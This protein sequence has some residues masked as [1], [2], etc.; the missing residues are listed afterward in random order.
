MGC[1]DGAV[2]IIDREQENS[3][4]ERRLLVAKKLKFLRFQKKNKVKT[5]KVASKQRKD[6]EPKCRRIPPVIQGNLLDTV[7]SK[8]KALS[9]AY[10]KITG[11]GTSQTSRIVNGFVLSDKQRRW[12]NYFCSLTYG[13]STTPFCG[14]SYIGRNIVITAAHCVDWLSS[15]ANLRVRFNKRYLTSS[16]LT[17]RVKRI[18]VHPNY[19]ENTYN[20]DIAILWLRGT[21]SRRGIKPI[22]R[23][24]ARLGRRLNRP[25]KITT[26]IG[27]GATVSGG[28]QS[29][30][31][32]AANIRIIAESS[33]LNA[34]PDSYI[35]N[36]M[37]LAGDFNDLADPFDNEDSCQGDSGGP[38]Y[39]IYRRKRYLVG[40][41]SWGIGCGWDGYPGVYTKASNYNWWIKRMTGLRSG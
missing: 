23:V 3:Y 8:S 33:P 34:Y 14:G 28:E 36:N 40:I 21:P 5:T 16:G 12:N 39:A 11:G 26:I 20:N 35:N 2:R 41:V 9:V 7:R 10:G 25:G 24:G 13:S 27:F 31:M 30:V 37:L 29:S 18:A 15:P 6:E 38:M 19:D 4:V 17:Y 1:C 22:N 32:R